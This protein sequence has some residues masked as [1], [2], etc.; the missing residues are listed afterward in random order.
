MLCFPRGDAQAKRLSLYEGFTHHETGL[1][2]QQQPAEH[3]SASAVLSKRLWFAVNSTSPLLPQQGYSRIRE[4]ELRE[5]LCLL[6]LVFPGS[7]FASCDGQVFLGVVSR[8]QSRRLVAS[9]WLH[10]GQVAKELLSPWDKG[11]GQACFLPRL[12]PQSGA[13]SPALIF[14]SCCLSSQASIVLQ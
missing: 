5:S 1:C 4:E 3:F 9:P 6:G 13:L 10:H 14:P 11:S 7:M 8:D 12:L 2:K